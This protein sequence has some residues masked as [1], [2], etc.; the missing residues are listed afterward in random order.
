MRT[1]AGVSLAILLIVRL[2]ALDRV[3]DG[4]VRQLGLLAVAAHALVLPG[5]LDDGG[6]LL[7]HPALPVGGAGGRGPARRPSGIRGI[8]MA[9]LALAGAAAIGAA[10]WA[11]VAVLLAAGVHALIA[12]GVI[13]VALTLAGM[14]VVFMLSVVGIIAFLPSFLGLS[15]YPRPDPLVPFSTAQSAIGPDRRQRA[16]RDP[17]V[18]R[19]GRDD[20]RQRHVAAPDQPSPPPSSATCAAGW[21]TSAQLDL[22]GRLGHLRLGPGRRG[23]HDPAAGAGDG[24][25]GLPARRGRR[26]RRRRLDQG[27]DRAAVGDVHRLRLARHGRVDLGAAAVGPDGGDPA[28]G[29]PGGDGLRRGAPDGL[30]GQAPLRRR[31]TVGR[32]GWPPLP[33]LAIPFIILGGIFSGVF[34]PT[35]SASVAAL[36]AI[37]LALFWFAEHVARARCRASWCW[38]ASRPAS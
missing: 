15:F 32:T 13:F 24:A 18:P 34:T 10:V 1:F 14:P 6:V 20:E 21:P 25:R 7:H 8:R 36:V 33:V 37:G 16:D 22:G 26:G 28:A 11:V 29:L 38:R 4:P 5:R 2:R 17:D 35:E 27:G 12:L 30:P 3:R 23:D 31:A 19:H 9:V